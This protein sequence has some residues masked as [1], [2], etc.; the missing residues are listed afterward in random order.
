MTL[1]TCPIISL[2]VNPKSENKRS[3]LFQVLVTYCSTALPSTLHESVCVLIFHAHT[4]QMV[5][6]PFANEE[7]RVGNQNP[8]ETGRAGI[9]TEDRGDSD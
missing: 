9:S 6:Y 3:Y 7:M 8:S 4:I 1:Y 2:R 5:L